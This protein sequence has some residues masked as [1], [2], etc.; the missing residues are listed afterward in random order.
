MDSKQVG[1]AL[2]VALVGAKAVYDVFGG[3]KR[4][5]RHNAALDQRFTEQELKL[6]RRFNGISSEITSVQRAVAEVRSFVV[7]PDGENGLRG[8]MK[9][10][11]ALAKANHETQHRR[12]NA[13]TTILAASA[14][15]RNSLDKRL[16]TV[17]KCVDGLETRERERDE[18]TRT[19]LEA[20]RSELER[21]V[22]EAERRQ[23]A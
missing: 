14:I 22:G 15:E 21:R 9:E 20:K 6:E 19:G 13:V 17:E 2:V 12:N 4:D 11:R 8:D 5:R 10:I 18:E 7:G 1:D 23:R 16:T 3:K